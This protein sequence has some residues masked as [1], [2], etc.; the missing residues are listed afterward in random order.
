MREG[1][2]VTPLVL[3]FDLVF[4]LALTQ[5][6][7]LVARTPTWG[8]LL[9]GLLVLG[10]TLRRMRDF[11]ICD[12]FYKVDDS[13]AGT[14]RLRTTPSDS[15]CPLDPR[16]TICHTQRRR[17]K[18]LRRALACLAVLGLGVLAAPS[19][20]AAAPTVT[21]KARAVPIPG[22]PHTGNIRGAGAAEQ[23]EWTIRGTEYGGFPPP[24]IGVHVYEPAGTKLHPRGFVP[25]SPTALKNVGA[26][27]CP[28]KSKLTIFGEAN[29][30]VSFGS[31]RV[32][33]KVSVQGFFAP[34][35]ALQFFTQGRSPVAL[36]FISASHVVN[37][38]RPYGPEFITEV[39][40]VETV[41]GAPDASALSISVRAGSAYRKGRKAVYYG[42][43]PRKCPKGGFP[44]KS[45]LVFAN[46]AALPQRVPGQ[47]VTTTYTAPC[48]RH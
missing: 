46:T 8:G 30:V 33:E 39:P 31:E 7:T 6:T 38:S 20:A 43:V 21:F 48:P 24:L 15:V 47:V 14:G 25:C 32:E 18:M 34:H 2:R 27:A 28:K 22:F 41:P 40:L 42:R 37:S 5:C 44:L 11:G 10:A 17:V 3:F 12:V 9:R 19:I 36:E 1:E 35:G 13:F 26:K 23:V 45:E 29:G 16:T 4:V